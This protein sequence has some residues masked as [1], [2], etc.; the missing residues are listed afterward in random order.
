MTWQ[1][2]RLISLVDASYCHRVSNCL[3][4]LISCAA[5]ANIVDEFDVFSF[6][7]LHITLPVFSE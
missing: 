3:H 6:M 1:A 4:R 5:A 7:M 2:T